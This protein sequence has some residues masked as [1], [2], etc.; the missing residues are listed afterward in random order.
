VRNIRKAKKSAA[1]AVLC[2]IYSKKRLN[3]QYRKPTEKSGGFLFKIQLLQLKF[4]KYPIIPK[5]SLEFL[6]KL[7]ENNNKIWFEENKSKYLVELNH[8]ETFAGALL[9]ELSKTDV[10]ETATGKKVFIVFIGTFVF[11]KIK[12]LLR[13]FGEVATRAQQ[14]QD[15]AVIIFIWK[16]EIVFLPAGFGDQIQQI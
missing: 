15:E 5:S 14:L 7:K 3:I 16:K 6:S 9:Q 11:Q 8:I 1:H 2:L 4:M 13:L 12:P 10:L